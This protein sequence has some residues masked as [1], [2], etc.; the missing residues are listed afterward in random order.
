[1]F[2]IPKK[3]MYSSMAVSSLVMTVYALAELI[4]CLGRLWK[5]PAG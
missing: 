2:Q 4:A 1:V 3:V 5:K